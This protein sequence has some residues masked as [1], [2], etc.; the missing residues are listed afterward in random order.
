MQELTKKDEID[1]RFRALQMSLEYGHR[2]F[3]P[4]DRFSKERPSEIIDN[5]HKIIR[6]VKEDWEKEIIDPKFNP[7]ENYPF[8]IQ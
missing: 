7:L 2:L 4:K 8:D 1:L 6:L 3:Q 5:A